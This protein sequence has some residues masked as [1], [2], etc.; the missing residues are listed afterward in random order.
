[1]AKIIIDLSGIGGLASQYYN[2]DQHLK[3]LGKENQIAEGFCNPYHRIGFLYPTSNTYINTTAGMSAIVKAT[4]VETAD[5]GGIYKGY[6]WDDSGVLKAIVGL[7]DTEFNSKTTVASVNGTD[8]EIYTVNGVRKLFYSYK[9]TGDASDIGIHDFASSYNDT[10]LS[11]TCAS[12][13]NLGANSHKMISADN[14][15][16]YILDGAAVHKIDG[17]TDGGANGTAT[18]NVLLFPANFQLIDGIDLRGKMWIA[19]MKSTRDLLYG[20]AN[21]ALFT[22]FCGVYVWDRQSTQVN[23]EDFIQIDGVREIRTIFTFRGIPA[24]F[25]VSSRRLTQLRIYTGNEFKIVKEL[26]AEAYPRFPDSVHVAGDLI[27][28]LGN[29]G[30]I[31][32]YGR[33]APGFD[34]ALYMIGDITGEVSSGKGFNITGAILGV[35]ETNESYYLNLTDDTPASLVKIWKPFASSQFPLAGNVFSMV[36]LLPKLSTVNSVTLYYPPIGTGTTEV[37]DVDIYFNQSTTSWGTT[38]LTRADG[39]RSYKYIPVGKKGVNFIQLGFVWKTTNGISFAIT[40]S[41]AEIDYTES[42]KKF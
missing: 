18:A 8:L 3:I 25:T 35:G 33:P 13:F 21:T 24:C 19:L 27:I 15:F 42:T 30:Y 14:G 9:K 11:A 1:M 22:E 6:F 12:G 31:Y 17:T 37:L 41:Y 7:T 29:N 23:M 5:S 32:A 16:M 34:D 20:I 4:Q 38:T 2:G 36:K 40:P 10:W 39:A 26:E 28:W